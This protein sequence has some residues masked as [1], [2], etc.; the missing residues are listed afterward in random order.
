MRHQSPA[1][2]TNRACD[3]TVS[4]SGELAEVK[5]AKLI[6]TISALADRSLLQWKEAEKQKRRNVQYGKSSAIISIAYRWQW[7]RAWMPWILKSQI[8]SGIS[9]HTLP[10]SM[11]LKS[12]ALPYGLYTY[13]V[14][15]SLWDPFKKE[16]ITFISWSHPLC[17]L[18]LKEFS[19]Y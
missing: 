11:Q 18:N 19:S 3:A 10:H 7:G 1:P 9:K 14:M 6:K 4:R 12:E 8:V 5:E 15:S 13:T 16:N 17:F 2:Q